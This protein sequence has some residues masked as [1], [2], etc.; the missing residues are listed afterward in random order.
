MT[1]AALLMVLLPL[2]ADA[3]A[4]EMVVEEH[5]FAVTLPGAPEGGA[6]RPDGTTAWKAQSGG[7]DYSLVVM[8]SA[9]RRPPD[10][11]LS[12]M[13]TAVRPPFK[14]SL[15]RYVARD[16]RA[17][18]EYLAEDGTGR[19]M[20]F[21]AFADNGDARIYVLMAEGRRSADNGPAMRAVLDSFR[22]VTPRR[23]GVYSAP[24]G[25]HSVRFPGP[26]RS[27]ADADPRLESEHNGF[28]YE[29][30]VLAL[31]AGD[32]EKQLAAIGAQRVQHG[33]R[34][35]RDAPLK[36][37]GLSA[38]DIV[39]EDKDGLGVWT[40]RAIADPGRRRLYL[41]SAMAP[42]ARAAAVPLETTAF[43]DTFRL[44]PATVK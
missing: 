13:R 16:G 8:P 15:D 18:R 17:G 25:T 26:V 12:H 3:R 35:V 40:A 20:H 21:L 36:V 19:V 43:F 31:P 11:I 44:G 1:R 29:M 10:D 14:V 9:E 22:F 42:K 5:G 37:A 38:R 27:L 4:A 30:R 32:A 6:R 28:V 23:P 39:T 24:D 34:L 33:L 41:L 2:V 7:V